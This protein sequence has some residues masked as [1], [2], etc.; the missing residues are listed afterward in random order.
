MF[1]EKI[2]NNE[3]L[4]NEI[5]NKVRKEETDFDT[6]I[7]YSEEFKL[8]KSFFE[9]DTLNQNSE[10]LKDINDKVDILSFIK[11]DIDDNLAKNIIDYCNNISASDSN[12]DLLANIA[13]KLRQTI[14][15]YKFEKLIK[16][17]IS[18]IN[19]KIKT[20]NIIYDRITRP[21]TII[22]YYKIETN[23][24]TKKDNK[25][26]V[27]IKLNS[28]KNKEINFYFDN[29]EISLD[30]LQED[31]NNIHENINNNYVDGNISYLAFAPL[32]LQ[33]IQREKETNKK[34]D[35][36]FKYDYSYEE[37]LKTIID[38]SL[39]EE[40]KEKTFICDY[41]SKGHQTQIVICNGN[42]T[43][44][45][46]LNYSS[47]KE[48]IKYI[49]GIKQIREF[50]TTNQKGVN[51]VLASK[52]F[53]T[54]VA[55][56]YIKS[57]RNFSNFVE[58]I[59]KLQDII[60]KTK[61]DD[62]LIQEYIKK[63]T[64]N[65]YKNYYELINIVSK[66]NDKLL[67]LKNNFYDVDNKFDT[68][69]N[70]FEL[71]NKEISKK[72]KEIKPSSF[73]F[74]ILNNNFRK[75]SPNSGYIKL[76]KNKN[77]SIGKTKKIKKQKKEQK[78]NLTE[79]TLKID[80]IETIKKPTYLYNIFIKPFIKDIDMKN[81]IVLHIIRDIEDNVH[82]GPKIKTIIERKLQYFVKKIPKEQ[83]KALGKILSNEVVQKQFN[84]IGEYSNIDL[85]DM[86]SLSL[87]IEMSKD[88]DISRQ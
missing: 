55:Q 1:E 68:L 84:E 79:T 70:N 76:T 39:K 17:H 38:E 21:L 62:K 81:N 15:D 14:G 75:I 66:A 11:D 32:Q 4:T 18:D 58:D 50:H 9:K 8:F 40:N 24:N 87:T 26:P 28:K 35:I 63:L 47:P 27:S 34:I 43:I 12:I 10:V 82:Y 37:E 2:K 52:L 73:E 45:N 65:E 5:N 57:G 74:R 7:T 16:N 25:L 71:R 86:L 33:K 36:I 72:E 13:I 19:D 44:F 56:E 67:K 85:G 83:Q 53:V 78:I 77:I 80:D 61:G 46:T 23:K 30:N 60:E 6:T 64:D 22:N 31:I 48:D 88:N 20:D 51:C 42:V 29:D 59:N 41:G 3:Y 54:A 69:R 49:G